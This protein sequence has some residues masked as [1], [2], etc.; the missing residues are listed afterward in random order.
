MGAGGVDQVGGEG[1]P[2]RPAAAVVV[3]VVV[4]LVA[5]R[6]GDERPLLVDRR[7]RPRRLR[8]GPGAEDRP[9]DV[10]HRLAQRPLGGAHPD[11]RRDVRPRVAEGVGAVGVVVAPEGRQH[12]ADERPRHRVGAVDEIRL[13]HVAHRIRRAV[14]QTD[15]GEE[16][17]GELLRAAGVGVVVVA[18]D[19][20][21]GVGEG[22]GRRAAEGGH[23]H[24]V[25]LAQAGRRRAE[26]DLLRPPLGIGQVPLA[27]V[28]VGDRQRVARAVGD[29]RQ[30]VAAVEGV[31]EAARELDR[32]PAGG[33][34]RQSEVEAQVGVV[35]AVEDVRRRRLAVVE[36]G[37]EEGVLGAV[38][39]D[40]EPGHRA[41]VVDRRAR[42][43]E[44]AERQ[45]PAEAGVVE[46]VG[47]GVLGRRLAELR[48]GEAVGER[49]HPRVV[50]QG[51]TV[52]EGAAD[53]IAAAERQRRR[54]VAV[55]EVDGVDVAD[56]I[57]GRRR[58]PAGAVGGIVLRRRR[59]RQADERTDGEGE[60]RQRCERTPR[61]RPHS[62]L[63]ASP[64]VAAKAARSSGSTATIT[65]PFAKRGGAEPDLASGRKAASE[66]RRLPS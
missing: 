36:V 55:V 6:R 2:L 20:H 47:I 17:H 39:G 9:R 51:E 28:R 60:R 46:D 52:A 27:R 14:R 10:G 19:R 66:A 8:V 44:L 61:G 31:D 43:I 3:E 7:A 23:R 53:R 49:P 41:V 30:A 57:G 1:E 37:R 56:K 11:L 18:A 33:Q 21:V 42:R 24:V 32:L 34:A 35:A 16:R 58:E 4:G 40:V 13:Q 62:R 38:G 45:A 48:A 12:E 50:L 64:T 22:V 54:E 15:A 5:E 59:R 26:E 63:P 25:H 65:S 29:R